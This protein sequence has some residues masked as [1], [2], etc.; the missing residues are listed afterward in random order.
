MFFILGEF[1]YLEEIEIDGVQ[2]QQRDA[3]KRMKKIA[4]ASFI[5]T[6]VA[7]SYSVATYQ[8]MLADTNWYQNPL[9]T[10]TGFMS[11]NLFIRLI[12]SIGSSVS[13]KHFFYWTLDICCMLTLDPSSM[14]SYLPGC[15]I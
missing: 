9:V 15:D 5:E 13:I 10:S 14:F 12:G 11:L 8:F 4:L 2:F 6:M 7:L 3:N 1:R